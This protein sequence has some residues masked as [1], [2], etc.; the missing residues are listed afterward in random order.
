MNRLHWLRESLQHSRTICHL[1]SIE[2]KITKKEVCIIILQNIYSQATARIHLDKLVSDDFPINREVRQGDPLSPKL[3][4]AVM[5]EV[6]KKA[7]ISKGINVGEESLTN[8]RFTDDVTL[9][10]R[11]KK[12][13]TNGKTLKQPELI[14]SESWPENTQGNDKIPDKPCRQCRILIR[15]QMKT[16]QNSNTSNKP[17]TSKTLQ[18]KKSVPGS[19]QAEAVL[20][21][22][23]KK[24]KPTRKNSKI[25]NY[26]LNWKDKQWTTVSCQQWPMAAK[27]GLSI[28]NLQ[29]NR[30]PLK[31]QWRGKYWV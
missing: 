11:K 7:C 29:T 28:N 25:N 17:H 22:K 14:T 20:K 27:H 30:E 16:W 2:K 5:E 6:F 24:K 8:L 19:E 23:K 13:Q 26:P 12:T 10:Q 21:K 18:K 15:K 31:E 9:F 3:F 4:T 1:W